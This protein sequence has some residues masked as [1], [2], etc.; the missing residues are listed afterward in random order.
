MNKIK[1]R[2]SALSTIQIDNDYVRVTEYRF[3]PDAETKFHRHSWNYI[4]IP[5]TD[6]KLL[7]INAE[8][9]ESES[10]LI[11]GASYYRE[12]GGEH[13]VI[14]AGKELLVFI[15]I[16]IKSFSEESIDV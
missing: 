4:V 15:E 16:E 12:A 6:G 3:E 8:G 14:N 7:L 2:K 11:A 13:N 10:N 5:Q 1:K 9:K